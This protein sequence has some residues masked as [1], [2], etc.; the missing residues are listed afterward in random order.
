MKT[1]LV[2]ADFSDCAEYALK[3]ACNIARRTKA[4]IVLLH[5]IPFGGNL[6]SFPPDGWMGGWA[7]EMSPAEAPMMMRLLRDTKRKMNKLKRLQYCA[8]LEIED[9]IAAGNVSEM[10]NASAKRCK[11]DIIV[12]GTNGASGLNE[13]LVGSNAEQVVRESD[14]P[15]LS[16]QKAS[17]DLQFKKIV[18]AT[19][20]SEEAGFVLPF[21]K[22][23]ADIFEAKIEFVKVI[24]DSGHK[25]LFL[26]K[27][28]AERFLRQHNME[29]Y[30]VTIIH[31]FISKA[32]GISRF[33]EH[34][35]ADM[36]AIGTHGRHG[37]AHFLKGSIAGDVVNFAFLPVLTV[38]FHKKLL[39]NKGKGQTK[40]KAVH[41]RP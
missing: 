4:K 30:P 13:I 24:G 37:L 10:I 1:I 27:K 16:V 28:D 31:D 6:P 7:G 25:A 3:Y 19:D 18:L 39:N 33:A 35:N 2:P 20:F 5:V 36:I 29:N 21:V 22:A 12:M 11:A 34:G 40:Q 41:S 17:Q 15:V 32:E 8:G 26:A 9:S 38:N 14:I 23:F